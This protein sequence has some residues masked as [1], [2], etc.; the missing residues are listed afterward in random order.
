MLVG[1]IIGII[2]GKESVAEFTYFLEVLF[3]TNLQVLPCSIPWFAAGY[4]ELRVSRASHSNDG[5]YTG[6]MGE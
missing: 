5:S 6:G 3:W 4:V 2:D 1:V